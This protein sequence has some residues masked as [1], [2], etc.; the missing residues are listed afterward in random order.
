MGHREDHV[1]LRRRRDGAGGHR[2]D[3]GLSVPPT[4]HE[5]LSAPGA[6]SGVSGQRGLKRRVLHGR[7][8]TAGGKLVRL[9]YEADGMF[10]TV[11]AHH[12]SSWK[13]G[14]RGYSC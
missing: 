13:E 1:A 7:R 4:N 11:P 8:Q 14:A 2:S 6:G 3:G 10:R 9:T 5:G 12:G